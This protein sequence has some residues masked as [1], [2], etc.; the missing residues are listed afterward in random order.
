M[1]VVRQRVFRNAYRDSVELMRIA[2]EIERLPGVIR[3]GLV[4]CTPAN[5]A[6]V[7]E[8]GLDRGLDPAAGP[9]DMVV[10]LAAND[11]AAAE[12]AFERAA[13]LMR[14]AAAEAAGDGHRFVPT[15]IAEAVTELPGLNLAL[16]STPG[17]YAAAEAL[18]ALKRGMHVFLFSDNVP[19]EDEIELKQLGV[20]KGLLVMGP[21]CGT[22]ILDGVPL[23]F[24]NAVRRGGVGLV[25][26]SG[27]GLQQVTCLLDA[28]GA[29]VS[30]AIGVGGRDL[31]EEVGGLMML[32]GLE[33]L[34]ADAETDVV[35]LIS[36]PPAPSVAAKVLAAASA[37]SKP[38]VVNFLGGD[39]DAIRASGVHPA[40]TFEDAAQTAAALSL[41][42]PPPQLND[43]ASDPAAWAAGLAPGQDR[44]A[45]LYSGGSLASEAKVV[46]KGLL[47]ADAAAQQEIVDL[48]DDEY[49]V[50]RPHPMIDP[51]L[52]MEKIEEAGGDP[53]VAVIL[54]DIV[55]G[56]ASHPDPAGALIPAIRAADAAAR[57]EGRGLAIVASVC[58]T[59]NDPQGFDGQRSI[60]ADAGVHLAASNA[61]AAHLAGLVAQRAAMREVPA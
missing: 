46:L 29:G 2:A 17:T 6:I 24:A 4:M 9:N 58:G 19:V 20:R 13:T 12:T 53:R 32:A 16:I 56:Y 15:T 21:D 3:A 42:A 25:G 48:G 61:R 39:A 59:P 36:K 14:G 51:R 43:D 26:A 31:H 27:T 34:V 44:I 50:G 60:L 49:T 35:V 10:A 5:L 45:G 28:F 7:A 11:D 23:G 30:Q 18:K 54:L 38:V 41:G 40:T 52:R 22:A 37:A 57:A 47:G 33:R 8:A 55:L 1:S